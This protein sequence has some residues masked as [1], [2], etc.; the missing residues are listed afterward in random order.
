MKKLLWRSFVGEKETEEG[1]GVMKGVLWS[2][3][4]SLRETAGNGAVFHDIRE[5][6][7]SSIEH[8]AFQHVLF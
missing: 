2:A 6:M 3:N 8:P 7:P 4:I 5:N 1:M